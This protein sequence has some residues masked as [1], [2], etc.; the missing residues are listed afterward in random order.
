MQTSPTR[1]LV[2]SLISI[3]SP[4]IYLSSALCMNTT[5]FFH[6][7]LGYQWRQSPRGQ[8][9]VPLQMSKKN[10]FLFLEVLYPKQMAPFHK[11]YCQ[12]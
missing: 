3:F 1:V 12:S 11:S 9:H 6:I 5:Y 10:D 8:C 4:M 2:L 7:T